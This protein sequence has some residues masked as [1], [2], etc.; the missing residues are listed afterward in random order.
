[1]AIVTAT[2]ALWLR[3]FSDPPRGRVRKMGRRWFVRNVEDDDPDDF[4]PASFTTKKKAIAFAIKNAKAVWERHRREIG[5][6]GPI[7]WLET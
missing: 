2:K 6:P 4:L 1:M 7:D 3:C 5:T